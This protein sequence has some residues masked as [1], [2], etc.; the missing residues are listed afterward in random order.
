[1]RPPRTVILVGKKK[2]VQPGGRCS[3]PA[4][5]T[6]TTLGQFHRPIVRCARGGCDYLRAHRSRW[7][8]RR[9]GR[10]KLRTAA[11]CALSVTLALGVSA[12]GSEPESARVREMIEAKYGLGVVSCR[13]AQSTTNGRGAELWRCDLSSPRTDSQSGITDT[14]WCVTNATPDDEFESARLAYPRARTRNC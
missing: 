6:T 9:I 3:V 4:R 12:C 2:Q 1:M 7:S 8:R 14:A 5:V 11:W 13:V 10:R